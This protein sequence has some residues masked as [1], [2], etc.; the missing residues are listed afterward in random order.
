MQLHTP[1][2]FAIAVFDCSEFL[3]HVRST[4]DGAQLEV[5][6]GSNGHRTNL[7]PYAACMKAP[8]VASLGHGPDAQAFHEK[9]LACANEYLGALGVDTESQEPMLREY[10]LNEMPAGSEH[11]AHSHYG[12]ALSGC[13]YVDMPENSGT[14][15]FISPRARFDAV[16]LEVETFS[17]LNC[18]AWQFAPKPGEF[19]LWESW[20]QHYVP[21]SNYTGIRR[22]TALDIVLKPKQKLQH[23]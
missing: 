18:T 13:F 5:V 14:I 3:P 4:F 20:L 15:V 17:S 7:K 9:L 16:A 21:A 2:A 6:Q 1:F 22:S 12:S 10:W 19:Y 8:E 11:R 23:A